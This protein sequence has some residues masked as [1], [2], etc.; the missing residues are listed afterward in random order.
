MIKNFTKK[1]TQS[2][3]I[4]MAILS[5]IQLGFGQYV[6][7]VNSP[8]DIAGDYPVVRAAFGDQSGAE[9]TADLALGND[10]MAVDS[11]GD[12]APGTETDGCEAI[13]N[14]ADVSGKV[15]VIDRGECNFSLKGDNVAATAAVA[16]LVC[17]NN[18]DDPFQMTGDSQLSAP[19]Y[20]MS[21]ADCEVIKMALANGDVNGTFKF[22]CEVEYPED[23]FWGNMEGQGD[24]NGGLGDWTTGD[25]TIENSPRTDLEFGWTADGSSTCSFFGGNTVLSSNSICN[26]AAYVDFCAWTLEDFPNP[27]QPYPFYSLELVSPTID[28]SNRNNVTITFTTLNNRLN[29][30]PMISY[31]DDDGLNWS[32]P[33]VIPTDNVVNT[34]LESETITLPVNLFNGK[35]A[36]KVKFIAEGDFYFFMIDDVYL[37]E[38]ELYDV[39]LNAN[40]YAGASDH[41]FPDGQGAQ[42]IPFMVDVASLGNASPGQVSVTAQVFDESGSELFNSELDYG[43]LAADSVYEN[44]VFNEM[45]MPTTDAGTYTIRYTANAEFDGVPENNMLETQYVM[46]GNVFSK[47]PVDFNVGTW[48]Y[49]NASNFMTIGNNYHFTS[50]TWPNGTPMKV[51]S[52]NFGYSVSENASHSGSMDGQIYQYIDQNGDGLVQPDERILL[53][54]GQ[55]FIDESVA[56]S[57]MSMEIFAVDED[58]EVT[59]EALVL[60]E[61]DDMNVL[62][63][64]HF[65]PLI[66]GTTA[67]GDDAN[68]W[69]SAISTSDFG[70][71]NRSANVFALETG[72]DIYRPASLFASGAQGDEATR[73][74]DQSGGLIWYTPLFLSEVSSV[75]EFN[76]DIKLNVFPNPA[77]S[78]TN[79]DVQLENNAEYVNIFV[80]D[81][82]GKI[83]HA[84]RHLNV[85]S[86]KINVDLTKLSSGVYT[87]QVGTPEGFNSTKL[88][89]QK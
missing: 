86:K 48:R 88:T 8:A 38:S 11:N 39:Q 72:F 76:A 57:R 13:A 14:A 33:E 34:T 28:C 41:V 81:M 47:L 66:N 2:C 84:E 16:M 12:G 61:E 46:G 51:D 23:A 27:A 3:L 82:S 30:E 42:G 4:V 80:S 20:M 50:G 69:G 62:V 85:I 53:G 36:C 40:W 32:T 5:S 18:A 44:F 54:A 87:L 26:G 6:L 64:V 65:N 59:E 52:I 10:G 75:N 83:V 89:I 78:Y 29:G 24:F 58:G 17:N 21:Q 9:V 1:M 25:V 56:S 73:V 7:S 49:T 45:Y 63:I 35:S 22:K 71:F 43:V 60:P 37:S 31:S 74:Y 77:A 55:V 68:W 70:E 67:N 79:V 19:A 15:A